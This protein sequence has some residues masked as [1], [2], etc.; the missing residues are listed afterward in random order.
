MTS[1]RPCWYFPRKAEVPALAPD[2]ASTHART[3]SPIK[4]P[5]TCFNDTLRSTVCGLGMTF[6][7]PWFVNHC[8]TFYDNSETEMALTSRAYIFEK[9]PLIM[10][11]STVEFLDLRKNTL[12]QQSSSLF[13]VPNPK[14]LHIFCQYL[15]LLTGEHTVSC[16]I[17]G[18]TCHLRIMV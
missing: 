12:Y 13:D 9:F 10:V 8:L 3:S 4:C 6:L 15:L 1:C 14:S 7:R 2:R 17:S 11:E 16:C 5:T 18:Y